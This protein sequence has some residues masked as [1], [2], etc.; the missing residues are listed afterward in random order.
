[1]DSGSVKGEHNLIT[2][3]SDSGALF[4]PRLKK[5]CHSGRAPLQQE[6]QTSAYTYAVVRVSTS[7]NF[8]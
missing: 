6:V 4:S 1:M 2:A 8:L 5:T 7:L 3:L